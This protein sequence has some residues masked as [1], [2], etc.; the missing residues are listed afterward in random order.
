VSAPRNI[1]AHF[2]KEGHGNS[3]VG[4]LLT[5]TA[6]HMPD[7]YERKREMEA[8]ERI[9]NK[10]KLQEQPFRSTSHGNENFTTI[11]QT[12][13]KDGKVLPFVTKDLRVDGLL[14]KNFRFLLSH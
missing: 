5:K 9:E 3:T 7:P 6:K 14:M 4:H 2:P 13:G 8:K 10:K 1:V 11:K 12:F